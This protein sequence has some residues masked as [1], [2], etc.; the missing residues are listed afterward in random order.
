[1]AQ[2]PI[3]VGKNKKLLIRVFHAPGSGDVSCFVRRCVR[4]LACVGIYGP[5]GWGGVGLPPPLAIRV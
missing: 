1:M 4:N 3:R 2:E 5:A